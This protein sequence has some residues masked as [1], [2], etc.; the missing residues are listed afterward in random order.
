MK[1]LMTENYRTQTKLSNLA[2][3]AQLFIE[4]TRLC[5]ETLKN[6][7]CYPCSLGATT[8]ARGLHLGANHLEEMLV[9]MTCFGRRALC[10]GKADDPYASV[11]ELSLLKDLQNLEIYPDKSVQYFASTVIHPKLLNL[12]LTASS[13]YIEKTKHQFTI[14]SLHLVHEAAPIN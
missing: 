4:G 8:S 13:Q 6:N 10:L 3:G 11:D 12:Y 5:T 2:S 1:Y 9:L 14:L 7:Q